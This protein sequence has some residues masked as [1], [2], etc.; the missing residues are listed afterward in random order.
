MILDRVE[1][2]ARLAARRDPYWHRLTQGR[3][4]GFRRISAG[5]PG[6]WLARLYDG[7][8]YHYAP[9]G[10]FATL[11]DKARFDAAKAKAEEWFR[12]LDA[13][14]S[15]EKTTVKAACESYV[16]KLRRERGEAAA[17]DAEGTFRRLVYPDPLAR[18]ELAKL[19]PPHVTG[20]RD[21]VINRKSKPKQ[22]EP[23][24]LSHTYFNRNLTPLR[25]ALNLALDDG[26][27]AS[28]FAWSK[29]LRPL[30][31][32]GSEGRRKIYL[33]RA[34]RSR[35]LENASDELRPLLVSWSLLPLR[36]G[37][38]PKCR[39]EHFDAKQRALQIPAGKTGARIIPLPPEA[40]A[41]FKD[42]AKG[43]LPSAWLV[44]RANGD[45]WD[46]F[47]WRDQ[48]RDAVKAAKLPKAVCAYT[49][50]HSTITDLMTA[51]DSDVL[52]VAR[53]SGTSIAMIEK[54]YGHLRREHARKALETLSVR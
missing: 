21:R 30:K 5:T 37:E 7:E 26:N 40:F 47:A 54:H 45:P 42:C 17:K 16:A 32:D 38:V 3:F 41:H 25:A 48:M 49:L 53:L 36:P 20:W 50:R 4:I 2:R 34:Q 14:G 19:K 52:T 24:D 13:G 27:V 6:T 29:A 35:L 46:R 44:S 22:G 18:V 28:A 11:P 39:V 51:K 8:R 10:D 15:T 12:H 9:L 33:D 31:L 43:K 1:S 23:K